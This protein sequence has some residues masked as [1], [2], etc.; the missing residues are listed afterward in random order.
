M[1]LNIVNL[2]IKTLCRIKIY[3][4]YIYSFVIHAG[5]IETPLF[6][7]IKLSLHNIYLDLLSANDIKI[8]YRTAFNRFL[9]CGYC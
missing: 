1:E 3:L 6:Y 4:R 7:A 9:S 8:M 5:W 2:T